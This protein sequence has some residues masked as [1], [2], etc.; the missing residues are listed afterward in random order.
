MNEVEAFGF[1]EPFVFEIFYDEFK[2]R[3]HPARLNGTNVRPD[4]LGFGK[5][6]VDAMS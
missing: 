6:S 4:H 5:L 2:V 1:V 3:T